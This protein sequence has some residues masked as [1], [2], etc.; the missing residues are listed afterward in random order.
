[1]FGDTEYEYLKG[2]PMIDRIA[3]R[4]EIWQK[5]YDLLCEA[6][7]SVK[8]VVTFDEFKEGKIIASLRAYDI[9]YTDGTVR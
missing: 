8:D 6:E 2:S 9:V 1:M 4:K 5:D 3:Q 7:P